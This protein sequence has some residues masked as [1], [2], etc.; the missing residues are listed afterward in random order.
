MANMKSYRLLVLELINKQF[1]KFNLKKY[2]NE[3]GAEPLVFAPF[4][5]G[6]EELC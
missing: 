6:M 1:S 2:F 3:K 5:H 4:A